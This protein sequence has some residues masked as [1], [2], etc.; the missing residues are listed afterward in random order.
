ML[1]QAKKQEA[2]FNKVFTAENILKARQAYTYF[3][4]KYLEELD[5]ALKNGDSL[6]AMQLK[7]KLK[8][9]SE[10]LSALK[11][12]PVPTF[13]FGEVV[14]LTAPVRR[15]D[16]KARI[17]TQENIEQSLKLYNGYVDVYLDNLNT[18]LKNDDHARAQEVKSEL[19]ALRVNIA[20]LK[21]EVTI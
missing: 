18:A 2:I 16:V 7:K 17:F 20:G 15:A 11:E 4:D 3:T 1:N 5:I 14:Q 6:K 21:N 19:E 13:S 12:V 8:E 10:N 9:L